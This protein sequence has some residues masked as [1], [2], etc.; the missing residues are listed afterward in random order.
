MN[1]KKMVLLFVLSLGASACGKIPKAYQG[2]FVEGATGF[3]LE[4]KSEGGKWVRQDGVQQEFKAQAMS[5][6]QLAKGEPGIYLR[7]VGGDKKS[8]RLE[9]FWVYP[10]KTTLTQQYGF[11]SMKAEVIYSRFGTN[12]RDK[13][14][15]IAARYCEA[16]QILVD[17][18]SNTFNGG[19]PGDSRLVDFQRVETH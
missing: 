19:C 2:A 3:R 15:N 6:E 16:G 10:D 13:V 17:Q 5:A 9:I 7:S 14:S 11:V 1:T 12:T 18:V 4:L 8:D